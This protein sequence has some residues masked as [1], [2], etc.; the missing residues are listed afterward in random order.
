MAK[1]AYVKLNIRPNG[2]FLTLYPPVDGGKNLIID[3]VEAYLDKVIT[4]GYEKVVVREEL[5]KP[6]LAVREIQITKEMIPPV[7][8]M[9]VV[10]IAT[11]RLSVKGRFYPPTEGGSLLTKDDIVSE[12]IKSGVKYG[13]AEATIAAFLEN[14]QYDE[15]LIIAEA[16]KQVE[17]S[18]AVVTYFFNTDLTQKPKVNEDGSVDFHH[19]D[20]ISSVNAGDVLAELT[21]AVQ[22]KP[23]IDVCGCL[24]RPVKV[25]QRILR[26][27]KNIK[28][29]EDGLKAYSEV[30]G[31]ATLEGDQI[32]VSNM[33]EVPANVDTSTGDIEYEGNVLVH[34]NVLAGFT[35]KAKGDI[36]VEGVV[37]GATL[38]AGGH[39]I[40]KR[41]I[42]GMDR[43]I[44]RANGN[45]IS[46]FI[47][48]AT[49]EAGGYV[50]ADAIM[51]SN[52]SAKGDVTVEG[53]KGYITGGTIRSGTQVT[54]RTIGSAMGTATN[55]EVGIEPAIL[56]EYR[57][58][59]KEQED[60][61][62]EQEKNM[63]ML[64]ALAKRIKLGEKLPPDKML[65][66]RKATE[67][68]DTMTKR[69]DEIVER[70][71]VLK[72]TIDNYEGG[73]VK[74]NST[75]YA[76]VK[77]TISN[78][79]YYVKSDISYCRFFKYQGDVKVESYS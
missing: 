33:Y 40:L 47:E 52:V 7:N 69:A 17:G 36:V 16:T 5:K 15:S 64:L 23:G 26:V 63:Q 56:A 21:P 68:R 57:D 31:H 49:V 58:L 77:L 55:L 2:T 46:R 18:D 14:R 54:A 50:T 62:D 19:L 11:D 25:K 61:K 8:E 65:Q 66:F 22:G 27:G 30:N 60:L 59:G 48:S 32:F 37:E 12:M 3:E 28:L 71:K 39:I 70:M 1:G 51:H 78:A 41:G 75:V 9:V 6:L 72:E 13:V 45:V 44:L 10:T 79:V 35:I 24:L 53:K 34:G 74:A 73:C 4:G 20:V 42:Q 38:Y 76:G 43:G 67:A 29:S